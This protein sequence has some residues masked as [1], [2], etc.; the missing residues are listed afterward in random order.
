MPESK[1]E[2]ASRAKEPDNTNND[3]SSVRCE[4]KGGDERDKEACQEPSNAKHGQSLH[5]RHSEPKHRWF[6]SK[7]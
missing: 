2:E 6:F 5:R 7:L 1:E 4:E 3:S